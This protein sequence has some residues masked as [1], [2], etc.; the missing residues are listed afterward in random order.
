VSRLSVSSR[1]TPVAGSQHQAIHGRGWPGHGDAA[2]L[3]G[4]AV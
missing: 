4:D 1:L 3:A 2:R